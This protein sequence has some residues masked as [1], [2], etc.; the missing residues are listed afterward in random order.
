MKSSSSK[1]KGVRDDLSYN[2]N[3]NV[4]QDPYDHIESQVSIFDDL[5]N[6]GRSKTN[7]SLN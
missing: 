2:L 7:F 3:D 1:T 5:S 6:K 4:N